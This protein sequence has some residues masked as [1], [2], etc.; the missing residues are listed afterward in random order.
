MTVKKP[1][2]F[3]DVMYGWPP[4]ERSGPAVAPDQFRPIILERRVGVASL[5][6][7]KAAIAE[8]GARARSTQPSY[9]SVTKPPSL[10]VALEVEGK[11]NERARPIS[12]FSFGGND[13]FFLFC[14]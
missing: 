4:R 3:A 6:R 10:I 8:R 11:R 9:A 13:E 5:V 1:K 2:T 12:F 14:C 7:G